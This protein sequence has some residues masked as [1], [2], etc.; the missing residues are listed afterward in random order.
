MNFASL[1]DWIKKI[2]ELGYPWT[3]QK[4]PKGVSRCLLS[5]SSLFCKLAKI[6]SNHFT[7]DK[8]RLRDTILSFSREDGML[9]DIPGDNKAITQL[10]IVSETRQSFSG[11]INLGFEVPKF[12]CSSFFKE[13]L[14]F[15]KDSEWRN[16][17]GAGAHLSHY[18]FFMTRSGQPDKVDE[19][20][21]NLERFEQPEG[22]YYKTC[23]D[24]HTLVNGVMKVMTAFDAA[25]VPISKKNI[26][27]ILEFVFS[28]TNVHGG[29]GIYDLVYILDRCIDFGVR[30]NE[31]EDLLH[32]CYKEILSHQQADG[33]FSFSRNCCQT[34]YYLKKIS[35]P[36]PCGD[37][38][39]TTLFSMALVRIDN[40]LKLG[41]NL[42]PAVT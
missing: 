14:Y 21:K 17:W 9:E 6:Y 26:K 4:N 30:V 29:C 1:V 16:P 8:E 5:S 35:D 40:R 37:I 23:P 38:H 18:L 41:L 24:P 42:C 2:E 10:N 39:G 7:A 20:L 28:Y 19:V 3:L 22:W 11:L 33:G 27:G 13:P 31:C 12:D 36:Y 25:N 32:L 15:M 34:L